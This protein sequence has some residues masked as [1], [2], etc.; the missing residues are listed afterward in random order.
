MAKK[1]PAGFVEIPQGAR[2][3]KDMVRNGY[4][5]TTRDAC[6]MLQCSLPFARDVL[7]EHVKHIYVSRQHGY[8]VGRDFF[9]G[10][11]FSI[12]SLDAM[13]GQGAVLEARTVPVW[14]EDVAPSAAD[15]I[16]CLRLEYASTPITA[17]KDRSKCWDRLWETI[18]AAL[19]PEWEAAWTSALPS[20]KM[21]RSWPWVP[22]P[23]PAPSKWEQLRN[24]RTL[25]DLMDYGD[26]P[27][28][29]SRTIWSNCALRLTLTVGDS[30]R[31]M[32]GPS[33]IAPTDSIKA[34]P[35]ELQ[36]ARASASD[37]SPV[38]PQ[39]HPFG[40][41]LVPAGL[42]PEGYLQRLRVDDILVGLAEGNRRRIRRDLP[43]RLEV[44]YGF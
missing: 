22:A 29:W 19:A 2:N 5:V 38:A 43:G 18:D 6:R 31:T 3:L 28:Q 33:L 7:A 12:G 37:R 4:C 21:Q 11:L 8:L 36:D 40:R 39:E 25:A 27:E 17:I 14:A 13:V 41:F 32:Y 26:S 44:N 15:E 35:K 24:Y 30:S 16:A 34:D 42:A 23:A 1:R 9:G 10:R 20:W